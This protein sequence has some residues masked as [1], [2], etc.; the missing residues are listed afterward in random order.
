MVEPAFRV[1]RSVTAR[2]RLR[3]ALLLLAPLLLL[4]LAEATF[5]A[6]IWEPLTRLDSHAGTSVR[7]KRAAQ[8]MPRIDFVTLGSSRPVYGID[9]ARVAAA[10]AGRGQVH[11]N[12][13]MAGSHW[14]T[15]G[16]LGRWLERRHPEVRG[17]VI[18][19]SVQDL[20]FAGNGSYELDIVRP[21]ATLA[22]TAWIAA[23]VPF[24]VDRVDTYGS[25]S[26][27]FGWREDVRDFAFNPALR[28][29][30]ETRAVRQMPDD[31][32]MRS[33]AA[34]EDLC[35][36]DL[37]LATACAALD[38]GATADEELGRQCRFLAD[39]LNGYP[40]YAQLLA[41]D[42]LPAFMSR[43]RQLVQGQL[44]TLK[45]TLPP[46]VV[47]M[48]MPPMWRGQPSGQGLHAWALQ[49]LQPL[50]AAGQIHLIDA[51]GFFDTAERGGCGQFRD[52]YHQNDDGRQR[53]TDWLLPQL[54]AWLHAAAA[55]AGS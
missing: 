1:L 33:P 28:L 14:M 24:Q 37:D 44:R 12:L 52:F 35:R 4:G 34:P 10:A 36:Y 17:G 43:T 6:G 11:A 48:P 41:R 23:H 13:S 7:V 3:R 53:F 9:H 47:L 45:W 27:L 55:S 38:G 18:A 8:A 21:F 51:T 29:E 30:P 31:L 25:Y 50:D 22:D 26:A 20:A 32:L 54:D 46:V 19:L 39:T 16:I 49:V 40:D 2:R 42:P 5:R 15:I